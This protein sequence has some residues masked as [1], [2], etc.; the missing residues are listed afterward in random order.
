[1]GARGSQ[2]NQLAGKRQVSVLATKKNSTTILPLSIDL[3]TAFLQK[4]EK[5]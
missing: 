1:M 4:K 5:E 3:F 2:S